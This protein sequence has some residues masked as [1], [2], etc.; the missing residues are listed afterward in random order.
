MAI[1]SATKKVS[2]KGV[3]NG[4]ATAVAIIALPGNTSRSGSDTS[5]NIFRDQGINA[6]KTR[7]TAAAIFNKRLRNSTRWERRVV[8]SRSSSRSPVLSCVSSLTTLVFPLRAVRFRRL[9]RVLRRRESPHRYRHRYRRHR[10]HAQVKKYRLRRFGGLSE[11]AA[12][13]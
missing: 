4:D 8:S 7:R 3:S 6:R 10:R 2:L 5:A 12:L 9:H 13:S 1:K 11:G